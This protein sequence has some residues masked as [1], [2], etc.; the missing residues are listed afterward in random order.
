MASILPRRL[1]ASF[2]ALTAAC[3]LSSCGGNDSSSSGGP[4]QLRVVDAA[5]AASNNFDVLVNGTATLTDMTYG[6][7]SAF[8]AA[9]Q[10]S[11]TVVFDATGTTTQVL[12]TTFSGASGTDDSVFV[13]EDGSSPVALVVA[14]E[15]SLVASGQ[16]RMSF[17]VADP[18]QG[19]LDIYVTA[20]TA[21]L[22]P[23]PS[24]PVL[25]YGGPSGAG[26]SASAVAPGVLTVASGD[27]RIRAVA[28]GDAT[29][30]VIY[31][32]GPITL[33]SGADLL[34]AAI[35]VTGSAASFSFMTLDDAS[36]IT[37][38]MDQR[39]LLR[40]GNFAPAAGTVD[41]YLDPTGT[42][43]T[44]VNL[45]GVGLAPGS[46]TAYAAVLPGPY[47]GSVTPTGQ[48][49]PLVQAPLSLGAST[50]QSVYAVGLAGQPSPYG[51]QVLGVLDNL[52]VPTGGMANLRILQFAP[53]LVPVDVVLL[54]TSGSTPVITNRIAANLAYP[55]ASTY[56]SLP[57][58]SYTLALVPTGLDTPL[59]PGTAGVALSM[60]AGTINTLVVNGCRY[61]GTGI[62]G[63]STA[64]L[65][66]TPL[67]D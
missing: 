63:A 46:A 29:L 45:F 43:N 48:T 31:D 4:P 61:P 24:L 23:T 20:P 57:A 65:Q 36:N 56:I 60:N 19:P 11:N 40:A 28:D 9:A 64:A 50:S 54:D 52:V 16:A 15:N 62:C 35:P 51:L 10:G 34:Y 41:V 44:A 58:G 38:T 33:A 21:L 66:L 55:A 7:A 13:L 14:Q 3:L 42:A 26:G 6:Q 53:D 18:S 2:L 8:Q 17:V 30:T 49:V 59:L 22:S 12:S 32:S 47:E 37:Q 1:A 25:A 39:V 27:Y 5:L 67:S